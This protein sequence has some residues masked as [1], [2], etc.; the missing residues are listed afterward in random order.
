[1]LGSVGWGDRGLSGLEYRYNSVLRGQN[2]LR[3]TVSDA[4]GQ[5]ISI[6]DVRS[7]LPGKT[8]KLTLDAALQDEVEQVLAGVGA[9]Y[10]PRGRHRDRHESRTPGR[11]WPSPTGRGSTPTT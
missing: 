4:I 10:S 11:S 9:Q 6:D 8:L 3:R 5:P 1:M 7:T 2:G